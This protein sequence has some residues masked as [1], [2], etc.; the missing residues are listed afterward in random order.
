MSPVEEP[1]YE[2]T[3]YQA[4]EKAEVLAFLVCGEAGRVL[5]LGRNLPLFFKGLWEMPGV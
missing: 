1:F 2:G 3:K 5:R 4:L